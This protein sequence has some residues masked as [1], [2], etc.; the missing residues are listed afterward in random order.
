MEYLQ[1]LQQVRQEVG[2]GAGQSLESLLR[3]EE[4]L[5]REVRRLE[6]QVVVLSAQERHA[7]RVAVM[8]RTGVGVL[9]A[10]VCATE[11][12]DFSR[13]QNR[14]QVGSFLGLTPGSH[15]SG[16]ADD[17]KGHIT[18]QGPSRVR[19]VLCQCV[20]S[21][22]RTAPGERAAYERIAAKNPKHKKIAVVALM[23]RLAVR[24]WHE[25][26]SAVPEAVPPAGPAGLPSAAPAASAEA[27]PSSPPSAAARPTPKCRG[28]A[29]SQP[30]RRTVPPGAGS[31]ALDARA[32]P[33]ANATP[34]A[35]PSQS[36]RAGV[37]AWLEAAGAGK[38]QTREAQ[39]Q[40]D[41]A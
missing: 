19:K 12:G 31:G 38:P 9:T 32:E 14:R 7:G 29:R 4:F 3:Q 35:K 1:W 26:M 8:R 18:R 41:G 22:L 17:R 24:L 30:P 2:W 25:V 33:V 16:Q 15:E 27:L 39:A 10:M 37:R 34:V 6:V 40:E 28:G 5:T 36:R 13:F 21:R 11:I 23:R 20:W